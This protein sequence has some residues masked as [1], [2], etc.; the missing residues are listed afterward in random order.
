VVRNAQLIFQCAEELAFDMV[1]LM[2]T[3]C[4]AINGR[5]GG[6]SRQAQGG[7]SAVEKLEEAL[8]GAEDLL[9]KMIR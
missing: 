5:G 7:G 1:Q 2:E 9:F 8:Q 3:A 4:S 6:R